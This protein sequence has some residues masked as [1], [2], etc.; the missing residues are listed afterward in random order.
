MDGPS[1]R[2]CSPRTFPFLAVPSARRSVTAVWRVLFHPLTTKSFSS[3]L[4]LHCQLT[5]VAIARLRSDCLL[6]CKNCS[7]VNGAYTLGA[8]FYRRAYVNAKES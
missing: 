4:L 1:D 3:V 6:L 7:L 2:N 5:E 8:V